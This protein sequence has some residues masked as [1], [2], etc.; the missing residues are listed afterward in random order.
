MHDGD[1]PVIRNCNLVRPIA[2]ADR[3]HGLQRRRIDEHQRRIGLVENEQRVR[4]AIRAIVADTDERYDPE[5]LWPANEWDAWKQSLPLKDLYAGAAGIVWA[6]DV[7]RRDGHAEPGTDLAGAL[8]RALELYRAEPGFMAGIELPS[9]PEASLLC[10]EAGILVVA[11]RVA[12]SADRADALFELVRKNVAN[13]AQEP[14]WGAPGTMLAAHALHAWTGEERWAGARHESAEDVRAVSQA[15]RR[16]LTD[17]VLRSTCVMNLERVRPRYVLGALVLAEWL[18]VFVIAHTAAHRGWIY[19]QGGDQL[20]YYTA[21]WL[22]AHGHFPVP[23]LG[24]LWSA[25]LYLL[26]VRLTVRAARQA[27]PG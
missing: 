7:L 21:G 13:E 4:A 9:T 19:Y 24:Y 16:L 2:R 15:I 5:R 17:D 23:V 20:W 22:L 8:D 11:S 14:M 26:R 25:V 1:L 6:L 12:P 27:S 18:V 10:G 3:G